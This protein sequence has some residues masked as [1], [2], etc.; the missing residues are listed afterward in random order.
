MKDGRSF[1]SASPGTLGDEE[2]DLH[3]PQTGVVSGASYMTIRTIPSF[4]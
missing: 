2:D 1:A 4:P 3:L